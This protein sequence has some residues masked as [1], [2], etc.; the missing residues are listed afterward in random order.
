MTHTLQHTPDTC[1]GR[2]CGD[3]CDHVEFLPDPTVDTEV[4]E[5]DTDRPGF[6]RRVRTK[7]VDEVWVELAAALGYTS[8]EGCYGAE[9]YMNVCTSVPAKQPW[10][11]GRIVVYPVTGGNEG[12]YIHVAVIHPGHP[13]QVPRLEVDTLIL[14]KTF[15]GWDAAW[16]FA[17]RAARILGV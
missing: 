1:P 14:A 11:E 2:P 15:A 5:P 12:H 10:P 4:W 13:R 3:G 16:D 9:E 6:L 17:K 7:T 8:D